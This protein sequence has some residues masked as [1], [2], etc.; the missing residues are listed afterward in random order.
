MF[1]FDG[2]QPAGHLSGPSTTGRP[3]YLHQQLCID[4]DEML[5]TQQGSSY[6]DRAD[7]NGIKIYRP[8]TSS[9]SDPGAF[10]PT[11]SESN[12]Q[13]VDKAYVASQNEV[14]QSHIDIEVA[15][16]LGARQRMRFGTSYSIWECDPATN[17]KC[18]VPVNSK[19]AHACYSTEGS[20]T[21]DALVALDKSD[22][23]TL[24]RSNFT[25]PCSAANL[26]T[27]H[28]VGGKILPMYWFEE[29]TEHATTDEIDL[30][31]AYAASYSQSG[32]NFILVLGLAFVA[33]FVG[34][35]MLLV[36]NLG[37]MQLHSSLTTL[38]NPFHLYFQALLVL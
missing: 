20:A 13:L 8:T 37:Q 11:V 6:A 22:L 3:E 16:G 19:G 2:L 32:N 30:L 31:A 24:G 26:F 21:F 15:S 9:D 7:G 5:Y 35:S 23:T 38:T 25:Y 14:L 36:S 27:P 34:V 17:E 1:A 29:S 12:Y 33:M 10:D 28:V 4:G 18:K